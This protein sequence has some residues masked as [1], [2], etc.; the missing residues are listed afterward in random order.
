MS[1]EGIIKDLRNEVESIYSQRKYLSEDLFVF[2]SHCR[3]RNIDSVIE[4]QY[5]AMENDC[6]ECQ[7]IRQELTSEV[8]GLFEA[9]G[10]SREDLEKD[11]KNRANR[12]NLI[13]ILQGI[14]TNGPSVPLSFPQSCS[15][16]LTYRCN[17]RCKH[18]YIGV[19]P[20]TEEMDTK[21]ALKVIGKIAETGFGMF[22]LCGGEPLMRDDLSVIAKEIKSYGM[23]V[24]LSTNG[25]LLSQDKVRELKPYV[26]EAMISVDSHEESNHDNFRGE[27][28][29]LKL[30]LEGIRNCV[31]NDIPVNIYTTLTTFIHTKL[32][33]FVNCMKKLKVSSITFFD[34]NPVGRGST[35]GA[36]FR[37][38][39]KDLGAA[40]DT[41]HRLKDESD[42]EIHALAP[43]KFVMDEKAL[44]KNTILSG[45]FCNAGIN[46]LSISPDG[47]L[48]AC[49][50][51]RTKLG[52]AL[53]D[54]IRNIWWSSPVLSE[55]RDRSKLKG[56]CGKC[57]Y[58]YV[59]G[60]C[61]A[62]AYIE[63]S[64]HLME[65]PRCIC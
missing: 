59:C 53:R 30:S 16:E 6:G 27:A 38:S 34:L 12:K 44:S 20:P 17:L 25:T 9:L 8:A 61:R 28:G 50:R 52:N 42:V 33:E 32:P 18:C 65:D 15:F 64:D 14:F 41:L 36:E 49:T 31:D 1:V 22:E 2:C 11:L 40:F 4:E 43:F 19:Q 23:T 56:E 37:L 58:K 10:F 45:G 7:S 62:N 35:V 60:G 57:E 48:F 26:D 3:K 29:A 63:H 54:E 47:D 46:S 5:L 13:A 21:S 55:L 51:V 24:N 39:L